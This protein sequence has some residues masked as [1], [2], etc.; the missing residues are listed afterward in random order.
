WEIFFTQAW[1]D[2]AKSNLIGGWN[3]LDV[4]M[5]PNVVMVLATG[6]GIGKSRLLGIGTCLD[7]GKGLGVGEGDEDKAIMT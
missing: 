4:S 7:V 6:E 2:V 3:G 1:E 5:T